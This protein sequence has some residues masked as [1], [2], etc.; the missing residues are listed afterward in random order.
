SGAQKSPAATGLAVMAFLSAGHVPGEGKYGEVVEKGIRW[1]VKQQL[2]NGLIG[3]GHGHDMYHHGICTLM[4]AEASG[5]C[6]GEL[7][8]DVRKALEKAIKLTLQA[9]RV[10]GEPR[11]GWRY[12]VSHNDGSD[13]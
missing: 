5:M 9:Q 7:A 4:L 8:K 12:S 2:A 6:E 11:G 3:Q 10:Q 13:M 1:V